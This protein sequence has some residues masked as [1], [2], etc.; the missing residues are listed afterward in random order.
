MKTAFAWIV[1]MVMLG[2]SGYVFY[3]VLSDTRPHE[4]VT[5]IRH[6]DTPE[7][8]VTLCS[9]SDNPDYWDAALCK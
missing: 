9:K 7:G 8:V 6:I 1:L 3:S 2:S 5:S 4:V